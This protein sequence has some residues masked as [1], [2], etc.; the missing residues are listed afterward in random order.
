M[1]TSHESARVDPAG[2][3]SALAA[4]GAV[5]AFGLPAAAVLLAVAAMLFA[6]VSRR[7]LRRDPHLRG[8]R[9][10]LAG[11][12]VGIG[13]ALVEVTPALIGLVLVLVGGSPGGS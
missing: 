11:F 6:V 7:R 8:S 2:I 12:L 1:I 5:I 10:A 9:L 3:L 13:V 4:A